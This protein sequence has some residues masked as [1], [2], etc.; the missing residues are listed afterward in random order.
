MKKI[1][2]IISVN[3]LSIEEGWGEAS[4][5]EDLGGANLFKPNRFDRRNRTHQHG[6]DQKHQHANQQRTGVQ[7][8]HVGQIELDRNKIHVVRGLV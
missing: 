2:K 1:T 5:R 6:R 8:Q 7:Q 3:S 4:F